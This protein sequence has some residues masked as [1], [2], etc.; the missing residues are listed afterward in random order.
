MT[1][2]IAPSVTSSV[3]VGRRAGERRRRHAAVSARAVLDDDRLTEPLLQALAH[4][5]RDGV[6]HPACRIGNDQPDGRLG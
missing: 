5:A 6:R 1:E 3:T 2:S 4:E